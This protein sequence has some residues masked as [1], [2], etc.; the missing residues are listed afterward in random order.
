MK[1]PPQTF[2]KNLSESFATSS[3]DGTISD[4]PWLTGCVSRACLVG[5]LL[6]ACEAYT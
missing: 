1:A 4:F 6:F 3:S 2:K 5:S